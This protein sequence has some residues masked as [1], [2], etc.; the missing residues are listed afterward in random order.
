MPA[1]VRIL[2]PS[3]WLFSLALSCGALCA[4]A[5]AAQEPGPGSNS[6][7]PDSVSARRNQSTASQPIT[8]P[9]RPISPPGSKAEGASGNETSIWK[10]LGSLA[11][12][13]TLFVILARLWK[14]HGPSQPTGLPNAALE[15]LGRRPIDKAHMIYLVRL[16]SRVLVLG[17]STDGLRTLSEITDPVEVDYLAGLCRP[18]QEDN[19]VAHSFRALF[20][21]RGHEDT[22]KKPAPDTNSDSTAFQDPL[23]DLVGRRPTEPTVRKSEGANA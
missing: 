17:S 13:L 22:G 5:L 3:P 9:A 11:V 2:P 23:G 7:R 18:Q 14:K 20:Q 19:Q 6:A 4:S 8:P 16:G 1:T 21:L 15:I 12:V 10:T